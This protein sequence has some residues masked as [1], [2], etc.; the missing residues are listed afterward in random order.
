MSKLTDAL[1][2]LK[3]VSKGEGVVSMNAEEL[4][5]YAQEQILKSG[6]DDDEGQ[7][8][9]A[10]LTEVVADAVATFKSDPTAKHE[11]VPYAEAPEA[12]SNEALA[13]SV[14]SMT[15]KL[16]ELITLLKQDNEAGNPTE[17]TIHPPPVPRGH[18]NGSVATNQPQG[19]D[20]GPRDDVDDGVAKSAA[21]N[22]S[23][24]DEEDDSKS[25]DDKDGDDVTKADDDEDFVW[26]VDLNSKDFREGVTKREDATERP[27]WGYDNEP[28]PAN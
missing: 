12:G 19:D 23:E 1:A 16:D 24:D 14:D 3:K 2:A 9:I 8:R 11:F 25:D 18:E 10:A 13:K 4:T 5:D 27:A 6:Q 7:A 22:K 26:P 15:T 20:N 21:G 28:P 17:D